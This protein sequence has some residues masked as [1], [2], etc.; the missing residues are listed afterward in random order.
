MQEGHNDLMC[1]VARR[2]WPDSHLLSYRTRLSGAEVTSPMEGVT[3]MMA[4]LSH[5]P[6]CSR[7]G[8]YGLANI[9]FPFVSELRLQ[10]AF[11]R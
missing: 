1:L 10:R 2:R 7:A 3:G 5:M 6:F 11:H 8:L 4:Q 9:D